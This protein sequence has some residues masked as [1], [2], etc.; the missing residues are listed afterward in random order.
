MTKHSQTENVRPIL[1]GGLDVTAPL[2]T[3]AGWIELGDVEVGQELF[4]E[5]GHVCRVVFVS[6]V[7]KP[8]TCMEVAFS[9]HARLIAAPG[10]LWLTSDKASRKSAGRSIAPTIVPAQRTTSELAETLRVGRRGEAN[11]SIPCVKPLTLPSGTNLVVDPYCL[12]YWL[13]NGHTRGPEITT[14]DTD[15]VS[16]FIEAGY[17]TSLFKRNESNCW[18]VAFGVRRELCPVTNKL[19]PRVPGLRDHLREIGVLGNKHIPLRYLRASSEERL[20]LLQGLMESDG[21]CCKQSGICEF[22]STNEQLAKDTL[23]LITSLGLKATMRSGRATL[24]GK[25]CGAKYRIHFTAYQR[26]FRLGRK[27]SRQRPAG[28]QHLRQSTRYV[29]DVTRCPPRPLRAILVDSPSRLFVAGR[30]M[31]A[32]FSTP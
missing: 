4:D 25:D 14:P 29:I 2:P 30:Q 26:V 5:R 8:D 13:G 18:Y 20:A 28:K 24:Y 19:L 6:D 10:Q 31:I 9:D 15:V 22:T 21:Y 3:P 27:A 16:Y 7:I 11:H 1:N 23:H 12:G 17:N 32:V